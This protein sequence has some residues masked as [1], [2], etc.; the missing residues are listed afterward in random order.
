MITLAACL[1]CAS[2]VAALGILTVH[3]HEHRA[4]DR[5][6]TDWDTHVAAALSVAQA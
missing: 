1:A 4:T 2:A 6:A 3:D 5:R